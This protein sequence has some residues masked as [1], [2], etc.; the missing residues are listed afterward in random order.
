MRK[1]LGNAVKPLAACVDVSFDPYLDPT[2]ILTPRD[3]VKGP[4]GLTSL[5]FHI[6]GSNLYQRWVYLSCIPRPFKREKY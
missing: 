2:V 3:F 6:W 1:R 5:V 4:P